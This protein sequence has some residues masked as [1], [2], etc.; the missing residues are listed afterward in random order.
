M[1]GCVCRR[2]RGGEGNVSSTPIF[3]SPVRQYLRVRVEVPWRDHSG[4]SFGDHCLVWYPYT[5]GAHHM[6][7]V[8]TWSALGSV[9]SRQCATLWTKSECLC[10]H[11]VQRCQAL[12]LRQVLADTVPRLGSFELLIGVRQIWGLLFFC[13]GHAWPS[14]KYRSGMDIPILGGIVICST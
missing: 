11:F 13:N 12:H 3:C 9:V 7:N 5:M 2:V 6:R 4:G 1:L 14:L 8:T 10:R